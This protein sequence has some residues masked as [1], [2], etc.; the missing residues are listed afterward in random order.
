MMVRG[1]Q[2]SGVKVAHLRE[3]ETEFLTLHRE[4]EDRIP[5]EVTPQLI[6]HLSQL[7]S[8]FKI[9]TEIESVLSEAVD[10]LARD[11]SDRIELISKH[12]RINDGEIVIAVKPRGGVFDTRLSLDL[13]H[14]SWDFEEMLTDTLGPDHGIMIGFRQEFPD[15]YDSE[16]SAAVGA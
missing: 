16:A 3:G 11:F 12:P 13:N 14:L 10:R 15:E 5:I 6:E 9:T 7:S 1:T 2:Q 8:V 4:N